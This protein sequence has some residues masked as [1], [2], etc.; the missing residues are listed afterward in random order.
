MVPDQVSVPE[1]IPDLV[2]FT[3]DAAGKVTSPVKIDSSKSATN[4][5][6]LCDV[7][8]FKIDTS[9]SCYLTLEYNTAPQLPL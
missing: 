7:V 4:D 9:P 3:A 1:I 5:M 8:F 2:S 6:L